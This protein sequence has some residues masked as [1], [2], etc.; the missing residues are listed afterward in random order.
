[1]EEYSELSI[2]LKTIHSVVDQSKPGGNIHLLHSC[3][4]EKATVVSPFFDKEST[5]KGPAAVITELMFIQVHMKMYPVEF[6]CT[7]APYSYEI[8]YRDYWGL[9]RLFL[10]FKVDAEGKIIHV[11]ANPVNTIPIHLLCL[12]FTTC[13]SN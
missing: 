3:I 11:H 8:Q 13:S 9:H 4:D 10:T 1:M 12:Q 5:Q 2:T 6:E 7:V